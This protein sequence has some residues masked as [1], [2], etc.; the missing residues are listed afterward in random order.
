MLASKE[1]FTADDFKKFQ[2]DTHSLRT[3][4]VLSRIVHFLADDGQSLFGKAKTKIC[5]GV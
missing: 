5:F 2:S 1:K 4:M 3:D